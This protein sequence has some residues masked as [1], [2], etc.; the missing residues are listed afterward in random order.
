M[1]NYSL[2]Q[3]VFCQPTWCAICQERVRPAPALGEHSGPSLPDVKGDHGLAAVS[4]PVQAQRDSTRRA[5]SLAASRDR[6]AEEHNAIYA[7]LKVEVDRYLAEWYLEK[8]QIDWALSMLAAK[9]DVPA[10]ET[11]QSVYSVS[12]STYSSQGWGARKYARA[13]A[14]AKLMDFLCHG[15]EG[16]VEEQFH[17][18]DQPVRCASGE[19]SK[20]WHEY[21]VMIPAT[22]LG[23]HI[24]TRKPGL[25]LRE[26]VK[27]CW[28]K[29][30]NP[31]VYLPFLPAGYEEQ[32]GLD[33]FGN[34]LRERPVKPA[35][36]SLAA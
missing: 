22:E 2:S 25:P 17:P 34:D 14:E 19:T 27:H 28:K 36:E 23:G 24:L 7:R 9:A 18:F 35:S 29:S 10:S 30:V 3:L 16:R 15:P 20:G 8:R 11:W 12:D 21:H 31:R 13:D 32:A 1:A 6:N 33:H 5:F 4:Q 26:Y